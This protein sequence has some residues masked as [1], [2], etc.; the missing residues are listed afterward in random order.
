MQAIFSAFN[1]HQIAC[2]TPTVQDG[3]CASAPTQAPV[4]TV[5]PNDTGADLS[6][7]AVPNATAYQIHRADG[8]FQCGF[9]KVLVGETAGT[10]FQ[11]SGLQNGREYSYI[12]TPLGGGA[13]C[14]GPA[15]SCATVVPAAGLSADPASVE[16]CAGA[17]AVYTITVTPP[18]APPVDM[19]VTGNPAG[20]TAN[21]SL[22][23]VNGPL[24]QDTVLTIGNTGGVSAGDHVMTVNGDDGVTSFDLNLLLRAF[25]T[26]PGAATLVAPANGATDVP[27]DVA[28]TWSAAAGAT[29][30]LVEV[31]DDA[32]FSS[33]EFSDS[34][35]GTSV[36]AAGLTANT[37]YH[38]R[39]TADNAC[40]DTVSTVFTFTTSLEYCA[41]PNLSIPDNGAAVTTSIVVPAGGSNIL[42]LDLYIRGN[43]TWVG[44]VIFGLSKDGGPNQL[45]FDRPGV[46]TST[47]G[48]SSNGP[49]MTLDDESATPVETA[50]PATDFV[51]TF[52][53]NVP[54][55]FFDGGSISGT[56]TLSADDNA[57]GDSGS[58]LE[59]CLIPVVEVDPM[60]FLD[61]FETGDTS[62]WS[63]TQN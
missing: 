51:G 9:G 38:W 32:N 25:T 54:L 61:G 15:S 4:V 63:A 35:T 60:P 21:F 39:V 55:S 29:G 14:M 27:A 7:T 8:E 53:P 47:F 31:D 19:S 24:P 41:T 45:H 59:W 17:S 30:Y 43:H 52:S 26:A 16:I 62:M 20:T 48:C 13:T 58:L 34:V 23:P 46:P 49:D 50:C 11:D 6:W 33:P 28:L 36:N 3:G 44:D 57:G 10:F 1:R 22:D 37:L 40:G 56:W 18:F 2:A 42:D 12:V 5:T